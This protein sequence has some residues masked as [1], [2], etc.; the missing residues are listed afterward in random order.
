MQLINRTPFAGGVFVDAAPDG[1]ETLVLAMKATYEFGGTESP[2]V[3]AAQDALVFSDVYAGEPGAS[4]LL[5]ESDANW[6][7]QA[8]DVALMAHAYPR[9]DADRETDVSMRIGGLVKTAHVFGDRTWSGSLGRPS[10]SSPKV[11]ERIPLIYERAFGGTDRS[12]ESEQDFEG[13][14]EN[15]VGRGLRAKKTRMPIDSCM[16]PNVED[17]KALIKGPGDRPRPVGFTFVAKGWKRRSNYAGT[18]DE[19]WQRDRMP[20]LPK[21]FDPRFYTAA[22][23]GLSMPFLTGGEPVELV[24]LTPSRRERFVMPTMNL[25]AGFH[26]DAAPTMLT[27]RLDTA[28][29]DAVNMKLLMVWHGSHPVQG[30]VDDVQW[31]LVESGGFR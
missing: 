23:E 16:L 28:I 9:R 2:R 21:D 7:R 19:A 15:P 29:I 1:T 18:Y 4:S 13:H 20:L 25:Q 11:F 6:G 8:A 10:V 26:I 12:P 22:S 30:H 31:V 27:M 24:N 3:A 5:Y 17:P 14:E